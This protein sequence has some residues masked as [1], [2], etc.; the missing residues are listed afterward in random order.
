MSRRSSSNSARFFD[1]SFR[2]AD[3][4]RSRCPSSDFLVA[5]WPVCVSPLTIPAH[6]ANGVLTK[7]FG[8]SLPPG[9]KPV[10]A[11]SKTSLDA[12]EPK[13]RVIIEAAADAKPF[14]RVPISTN[15]NV[16]ISFTQQRPY[17]SPPIWLSVKP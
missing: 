16:S 9:I 5:L 3:P 15:A 10:D 17:A 1:L 7:V 4:R 13:G 14:E 12:T 11:G 6:A 8:T 2:T